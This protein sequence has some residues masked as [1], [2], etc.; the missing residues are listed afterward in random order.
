[1]NQADFKKQKADAV[2][3][4]KEMNKRATNEQS[5]ENKPQDT[6]PKN[7]TPL[8]TN[9]PLLNSLLKD[10]DSTLIIGLLLILMGENDDK[11]LLFALMYILI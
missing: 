2:Q 10:S 9:I 7:N 8:P 11:L 6:K 5:K 3:K 4:M 1:M